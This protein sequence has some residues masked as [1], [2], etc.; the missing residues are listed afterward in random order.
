MGEG[1]Q[2]SPHEETAINIS[3]FSLSAVPVRPF[4]I[5]RPQHQT[6]CMPP[7]I[8]HFVVDVLNVIRGLHR[9]MHV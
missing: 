4:Q 3:I 1:Q 8:V 6:I 7:C 5:H 9:F 2:P